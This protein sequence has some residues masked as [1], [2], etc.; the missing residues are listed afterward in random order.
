MERQLWLNGDWGAELLATL[1]VFARHRDSLREVF[2]VYGTSRQETHTLPWSQLLGLRFGGTYSLFNGVHVVD[3]AHAKKKGLNL[4]EVDLKYFFLEVIFVAEQKH[5]E[6]KLPQFPFTKD[7][8]NK[9]LERWTTA[10]ALNLGEF[11]LLLMLISLSVPHI[12][13]LRAENA[14]GASPSRRMND[15]VLYVLEKCELSM[16]LTACGFLNQFPVISVLER[17]KAETRAML[18][19]RYG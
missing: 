3:D 9:L 16:G 2:Y 19:T 12:S 15:F 6:T 7:K 14:P 1:D 8:C 18:L 13:E 4:N 17:R 5:S 10:Y 11:L